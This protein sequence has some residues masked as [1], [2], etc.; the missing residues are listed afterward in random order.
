MF[1][2]GDVLIIPVAEMPGDARCLEHQ[3]GPVVLAEGEATGHAH[4]IRDGVVQEYFW[5]GPV[6]QPAQRLIDVLEECTV[7][8]EEH[9]PIPLRRGVYRVVRQ[10]EYVAP[11]FRNAAREED[12]GRAWNVRYV[13]D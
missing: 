2:Q 7:T 11:A 13:A 12:Y 4:A 10:R 6:D 3:R 1:R 9:A 5:S 8:H